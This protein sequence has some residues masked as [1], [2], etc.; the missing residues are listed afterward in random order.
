MRRFILLILLAPILAGCTSGINHNVV[1]IDN[2]AYL[3]ETRTRSLFGITQW[4]ESSRYYNIERDIAKQ[5]QIDIYKQECETEVKEMLNTTFG[6]T[7]DSA[8]SKCI[9]KKRAY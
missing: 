6:Q 3:I 5:E 7:Y 9:R 4:S 8:L 2:K 1:T